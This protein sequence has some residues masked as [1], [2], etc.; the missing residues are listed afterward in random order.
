MNI[1]PIARFLIIVL[2]LNF[3]MRV[4]FT[5]PIVYVLMFL[6]YIGYRYYRRNRILK[7][8]GD[9]SNFQNQQSKS[10]WN[11][12]GDNSWNANTN[13]RSETKSSDVVEAEYIEREVE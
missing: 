10:A 2:V 8:S 7:Q 13:S 6:G 5:Y 4:A 11:S 1:F 12:T 3:L 9:A